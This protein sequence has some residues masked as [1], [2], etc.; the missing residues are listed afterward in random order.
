MPTAN[1]IV[2]P[3]TSIGFGSESKNVDLVTSGEE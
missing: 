2:F 3:L 1:P